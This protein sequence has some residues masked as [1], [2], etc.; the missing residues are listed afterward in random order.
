MLPKNVPTSKSEVTESPDLLW[1]AILKQNSQL[2]FI[3]FAIVIFFLLIIVM[4]I[5]GIS[6]LGKIKAIEKTIVSLSQEEEREV[7]S[8]P[9]DLL[10]ITLP[11]VKTYIFR[12][13]ERGLSPAGFSANPGDKIK[14]IFQNLDEA[15]RKFVIEE[16]GIASNFLT[17]GQ[18]ETI[19]FSLPQKA[20]ASYM[21]IGLDDQNQPEDKFKA[22]IEVTE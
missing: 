14:I 3:W 5:G 6:I 4:L 13:T 15:G 1:L 21:I 8:L 20:P 12:A 18:E 9:N 11:E 17:Q 22:S 10:K 19:N 16:L 7:T 2:K